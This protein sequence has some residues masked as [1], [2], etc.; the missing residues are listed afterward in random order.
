MS[1]PFFVSRDIVGYKDA[2]VRPDGTVIKEP[3]YKDYFTDL[4]Q[5]LYLTAK[6]ATFV[7]RIPTVTDF[8]DW[9]IRTR[10][11]DS[12]WVLNWGVTSKSGSTGTLTF[13]LYKKDDFNTNYYHRPDD[14]YKYDL[15]EDRGVSDT[16]VHGRY[17]RTLGDYVLLFRTNNVSETGNWWVRIGVQK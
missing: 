6:D 12:P 13:T 10:I 17:G 9:F 4:N 14:L 5:V 3:V 7:P 1:G 11:P 16:G 2:G 8:D 15:G